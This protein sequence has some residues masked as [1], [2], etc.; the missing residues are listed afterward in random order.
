MQPLLR[1]FYDDQPSKSSTV[2]KSRVVAQ[3]Q[4]CCDLLWTLQAEL[5]TQFSGFR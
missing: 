4:H 2:L 1:V 3:E 5:Y